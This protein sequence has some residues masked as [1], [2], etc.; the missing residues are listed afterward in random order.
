MKDKK[1][2]FDW[3]IQSETIQNRYQELLLEWS[4]KNP[5]KLSDHTPGEPRKAFWTCQ[6]GHEWEA[7]ISHRFNGSDC[8]YCSGRNAIPGETDLASINPELAS[9]WNYKRNGDL[10][11]ENVTAKSGRK[12]WWICENGHE[13]KT[14]ICHRASGRKCP[15]CSKKKIYRG[16]DGTEKSPDS[17]A[18]CFPD[19]AKEW[20]YEKNGNLTPEDV[21]PLSNK[22]V[23]WKCKEGH[24][25]NAVISRRIS[26]NSGCPYCAGTKAWPGFND[27]ATLFPEEASEW[28][29][30]KNEK[31]PSE[32]MPFSSKKAFWICPKGHSY[33]MIIEAH[34]KGHGCPVCRKEAKDGRIFFS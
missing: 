9:E 8:P 6:Y 16:P 1:K 19:V 12:V 26:K 18:A 30:E 27:L 31:K 20:D 28:D 11:P 21:S 32:V 7:R 10:K 25:W 33:R 24:T 3:K 2:E 5:D 23:F 29:Y 15:Y 13:W 34:T 17:L 22:R 14:D 4:D